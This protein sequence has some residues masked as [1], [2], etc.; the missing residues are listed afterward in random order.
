MVER[1]GLKLACFHPVI[2][3]AVL[4]MLPVSAAELE[5]E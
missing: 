4:A 1:T 3:D 2:D 5:C